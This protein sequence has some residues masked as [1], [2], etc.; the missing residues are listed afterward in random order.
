MWPTST[1]P[2]KQG[3][4]ESQTSHPRGD[5]DEAHETRQGPRQARRTVWLSCDEAAQGRAVITAAVDSGPG[6][7]W[8]EDPSRA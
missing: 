6:D 5:V 2:R 8:G 7:N 3:G 4:E 1:G